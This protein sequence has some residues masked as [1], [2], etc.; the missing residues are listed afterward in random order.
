MPHTAKTAPRTLRELAPHLY[1]VARRAAFM[2]SL[3][4]TAP[5]M[6]LTAHMA[7]VAALSTNPVNMP[8]PAATR[9]VALVEAGTPRSDPALSEAVQSLIRDEAALNPNAAVN[10]ADATGTWRVVSAPLIDKLSG[11]ALTKFDI[12]YRIGGGA[13]GGTVG[14][15]VRYDSKLFGGGWLCTDGSIRNDADA[16]KPTVRLEW[17]RVW[18]QPGGSPDAPPL[19]PDAEGAA[20]LRP[21]I[22]AIG[23]AGFSPDLAVFP[24]RYLDAESGLAVFQWQGLTVAVRRA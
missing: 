14:A 9:V 12:T 2:P 4:T 1:A 24:V 5:L 16:T 11:L 13:G 3:T 17:E 21:L 8:L 19:D 7:L 10:F 6:R 22:Q 23:R 20:A 15:T 18:W